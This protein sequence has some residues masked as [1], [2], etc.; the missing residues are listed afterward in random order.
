MPNRRK[1]PSRG[2]YND[3]PID[4]S[5]SSGQDRFQSG[6]LLPGEDPQW[7]YERIHEALSKSPELQA[8]FKRLVNSLIKAI[9]KDSLE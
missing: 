5:D 4:P 9:D 7:A 6:G 8:L 3:H 2:S 1:P